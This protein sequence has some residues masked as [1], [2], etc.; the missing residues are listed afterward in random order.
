MSYELY[1][2]EIITY[3]L[4]TILSSLNYIYFKYQEKNKFKRLFVPKNDSIWERLKVLLS[5]FIVVKLL[6]IIL[7]GFNSNVLLFYSYL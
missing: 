1:I 7:V 2:W 4:I 3:T 5:S 6:E